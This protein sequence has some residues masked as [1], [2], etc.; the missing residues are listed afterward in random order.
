MGLSASPIPEVT[1]VIDLA[2]MSSV[3]PKAVGPIGYEVINKIQ[4]HRPE[5]QAVGIGLTFML[6]CEKL[7]VRP[8]DVMAV[9]TRILNSDLQFAPEVRA[10]KMYLQEQL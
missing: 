5:Q 7:G 9:C 6:L 1:T 3:S 8:G 4:Q 10:M 2:A